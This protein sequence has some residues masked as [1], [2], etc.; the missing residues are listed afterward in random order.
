MGHVPSTAFT[1]FIDGDAEGFKVCPIHESRSSQVVIL[2]PDT[3][4]GLLALV[5]QRVHPVSYN[6][7]PGNR[8]NTLLVFTVGDYVLVA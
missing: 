3:R 5:P 1:A 8:G 6:R 4:K 2:P 7:V